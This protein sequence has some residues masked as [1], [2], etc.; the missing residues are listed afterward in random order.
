MRLQA[1]RQTIR[2]AIDFLLAQ[3]NDD[4]SM[5]PVEEGQAGYYK[6]AY[7]FSVAGEFEAGLRLL[8]WV[9]DNNFAEDG[10]FRGPFRRMPPHEFFYLRLRF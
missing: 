9:R 4:G 6:V 7:A 10:D 2:R 3:Q 1:Y 5:Y 8:S